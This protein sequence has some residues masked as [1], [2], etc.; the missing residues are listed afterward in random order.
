MAIG[1]LGISVLMLRCFYSSAA[2]ARSLIDLLGGGSTHGVN[3]ASTS[4]RPLSA[5]T[6]ASTAMSTT[7]YRALR[8]SHSAAA[9][10]TCGPAAVE[11]TSTTFAPEREGCFS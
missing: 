5:L 2:N 7:E 11:D 4:A 9:A 8:V 1:G 6:H 10:A 3:A